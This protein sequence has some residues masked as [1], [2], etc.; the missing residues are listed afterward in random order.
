MR[1]NKFSKRLAEC[2]PAESRG[3]EEG[4]EGATR[5]VAKLVGNERTKDEQTKGSTDKTES[6]IAFVLNSDRFGAICVH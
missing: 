5:M 1:N 6:S 3:Q 2:E 4:A